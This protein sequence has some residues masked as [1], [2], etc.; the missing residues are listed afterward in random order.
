[1]NFTDT[2]TDYP[3]HERSGWTGDIQVFCATTTKYVDSQAYLRRYLHNLAIEQ[4]SG[5]NIPPFIPS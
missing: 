2:P 4:F 3:T 1:M 5:G